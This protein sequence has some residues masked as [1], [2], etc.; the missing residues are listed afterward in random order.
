MVLCHRA[1]R[2]SC[3]PC[4]GVS[5]SAVPLLRRPACLGVDFSAGA[6]ATA[7]LADL[8]PVV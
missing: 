1:S 7:A 8:L 3:S 4:R 2:N 6:G 5:C